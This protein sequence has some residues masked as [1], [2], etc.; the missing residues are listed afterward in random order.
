MATLFKIL[1]DLWLLVDTTDICEINL[2]SNEQENGNRGWHDKN[3]G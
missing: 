2:I 1:A 3:G